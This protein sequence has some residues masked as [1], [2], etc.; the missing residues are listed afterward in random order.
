MKNFQRVKGCITSHVMIAALVS[1]ILMLGFAGFAQA[2][3]RVV[4]HGEFLDS[5]YDHNRY[6]PARGGYVTVLPRDHRVAVYR[7]AHY[8]YAGG[9]W[10][11]AAGPRF[12]IVGPPIGL[13][14]P[15]LP[16]F[17]AAIWVGNVPYYYANETYYVQSPG[18]YMVVDAPPQATVSSQ[19]PPAGGKIFIYPRKGQSE[20]QQADDRYACHRWAVGQTGYDPTRPPS[21]I[22]AAQDTGKRAD[23]QRAMG[24]CLEARGYTVR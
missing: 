14:V 9:I 12:I 20:K 21:A 2:Q 17:Y 7:G 24:A 15:V 11:R 6:Y 22:R 19:P 18:G 1:G 8:Y 10:Y 13:V 4:R 5:H 23:Y 3:M 16:P